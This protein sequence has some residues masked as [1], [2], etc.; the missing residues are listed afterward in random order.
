MLIG[1][2]VKNGIIMV[3]YTNLLV[4]R[5]YTLKQAVV[6]AGRSR[7][8]PVIMTSLTM[9]LAMIPMIFVSGSG[10]EMWRP[11]AIA[12][13]GGLTL[14]TLVTLVLIPTIYTIFGVGKIKRERKAV[15]KSSNN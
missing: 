10:S 1:I 2:V 6:S 13:F 12:I 14:S 3:D 15:L 9:I 8:R 5:G 7:L 4:D 11:M